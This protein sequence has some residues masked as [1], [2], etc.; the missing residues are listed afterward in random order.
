VL[1]EIANPQ[2]CGYGQSSL[3]RNPWSLPASQMRDGFEAWR[4]AGI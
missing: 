2:G 3:I 1:L 4:S